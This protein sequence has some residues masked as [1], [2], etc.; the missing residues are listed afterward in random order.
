MRWAISILFAAF[1]IVFVA[2]A[3]GCTIGPGASTS[4]GGTGGGG[5]QCPQSGGCQA[6][7]ACALNSPCAML[8]SACQQSAECS[9]IDQCFGQCGADAT[10]KQNCYAN[11]PNGASDYMAV[12]HC[13]DCQQCPTACAGLCM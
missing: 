11:D 1:S 4:S 7:T 10:C 6:C 5:T 8:Y 2:L 13:V 3:G 12:I 9:A